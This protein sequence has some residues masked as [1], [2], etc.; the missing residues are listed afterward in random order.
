ME[1]TQCCSLVRGVEFR[2]NVHHEFKWSEIIF[3]NRLQ[4]INGACLPNV[5]RDSRVRD[6]PKDG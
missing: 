3:I 1:G 2:R 5:Q 6:V 4:D